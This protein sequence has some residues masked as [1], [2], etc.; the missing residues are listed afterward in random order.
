MLGD[1]RIAVSM[2]VAVLVLMLTGVARAVSV[3][4]VP[5][6]RS[7][8]SWV[9][10]T[11]DMIDAASEARIN[12]MIDAIEAEQGVEIALVTVESVDSATP[13]DFATAL[14]NAWGIGKADR[15]NGLLVLM[16]RGER[17]LEMET[18][19]GTEA[20]LTDGWLKS[21][22]QNVMVPAFK[23]GDFGGG[24]EGGI[25]ACVDRLRQYPNGIPAGNGDSYRAAPSHGGDVP[26]FLIIGGLVAAGGVGGASA[27]SYRK[28][29]QC[30]ECKIPLTMIPEEEDDAQLE[31][32]QAVE[33]Y[34]GS[35]D[36]QLYYCTK[37][38]HTNMIRVN[39]WFSG[40]DHCG[41]CGY[42]ASTKSTETISAATY[43]SSGSERITT[44]CAHCG[45]ESS[46]TRTIPM[47]VESS[48]SSDSSFGGGSSG[49]GGSDFGGGSSGGGGAG[50]SW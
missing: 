25:E 27:W 29:R 40:Y 41:A 12:A 47:L 11:V 33:E 21:M 43:S 35:V 13:K 44:R 50:S 26:W 2:A 34:L 6:P 36:Y 45:V 37:C 20:V 16:V 48:S 9:A 42:K 39:R 23:A 22:Q 8:N 3:A 18:G 4:D 7:N 30:P 38:S 19:Y 32:G 24:L 17:R 5:N 28:K 15:D 14:F 1:M 49:G 10:D 31:P 46:Y